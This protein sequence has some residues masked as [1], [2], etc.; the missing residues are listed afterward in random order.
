MQCFLKAF[1]VYVYENI[2][3][4][5]YKRARTHVYTHTGRFGHSYAIHEMNY[6]FCISYNEGKHIRLGASF[7]WNACANRDKRADDFPRREK[8]H[9]NVEAAE[10][11][12]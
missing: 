12:S 6:R 3:I 2:Y 11:S 7:P 5:I 8:V 1:M 10:Y 9:E 4:Y